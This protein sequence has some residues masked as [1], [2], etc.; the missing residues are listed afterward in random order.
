VGSIPAAD[1]IFNR[2]CDPMRVIVDT[3]QSCDYHHRG[4]GQFADWEERY[5]FS[6]IGARLADEDERTG[7]SSEGYKLPEGS[8]QAHVIWMSYDTG[9]SF[10][11]AHGH[12]CILAV[13]ADR[14][15]AEKTLAEI[16]ERCD[17]YSIEYTDDFGR[18]IK[19]HNPGAGYFEHVNSLNLET[20]TLSE[21]PIRRTFC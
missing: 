5:S 3:H 19:L 12:G 17:D 1:T 18:R 6:V 7:S 20:Y 21:A 4:E 16:E 13:F 9:D 14:K 8:S 2:E 10:G 15:L 11:R